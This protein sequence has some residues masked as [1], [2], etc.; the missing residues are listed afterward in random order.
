M[1]VPSNFPG[2][3]EMF[4]WKENISYHSFRLACERK[5]MGDAEPSRHAKKFRTVIEVK[6]KAFISV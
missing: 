5:H 1:K 4:R 3:T 6:M 2:M